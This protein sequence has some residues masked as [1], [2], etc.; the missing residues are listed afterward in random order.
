M[1]ARVQ[2]LPDD[3]RQAIK[4]LVEQAPEISDRRRERLQLLFRQAEAGDA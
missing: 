4:Q 2:D 3:Q 1:T